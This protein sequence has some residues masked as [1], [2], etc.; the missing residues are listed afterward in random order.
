MD[1]TLDVSEITV[2]F[3]PDG[4]RIDKTV[5]AM[6]RYTHWDVLPGNHWRHPRPV[7][8]H[9]LPVDGWIIKDKFDWQEGRTEIEAL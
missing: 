1:Q 4:F 9:D 2:G 6:N 3:H 8:F 7:C 5:A